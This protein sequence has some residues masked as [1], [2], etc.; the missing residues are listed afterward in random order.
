MSPTLRM[1]FLVDCGEVCERYP[2]CVECWKERL[3]KANIPFR[4]FEGIMEED[5]ENELEGSRDLVYR[6][7]QDVLNIKTLLVLAKSG[8]CLYRQPVTGSGSMDIDLLAG[9]IQ[10]NISF[11][12]EGMNGQPGENDGV[13][14]QQKGLNFMTL[15]KVGSLV[16]KEPGAENKVAEHGQRIF[17]LNYEKFVLLVHDAV[18]I[19]SVLV[20]DHP[21]SFQLRSLLVNFSQ[22]FEKIYAKDL[23]EFVGEV[24]KFDDAHSAVE[25]IF[26]T[27]LLF[28]YA[29]KLISP[30]EEESLDGLEKIVYRTGFDKSQQSGF[31]FIATMCDELKSMLQK[32]TRDIL[33]AIYE[34]LKL[35]YFIPQQIETAAKYMDEVKVSRD[36]MQ[37][38]GSSVSAIYGKPH[39]EEIKQLAN[40]LKNASEKEA[41][42][43]FKQYFNNANSRLEL[44]I[45]EDAIK[46]FDLAK[47]VAVQVGLTKELEIVNTKMEELKDTIQTLEYTNAMKIAVNAEKN[48]DFLKAIQFYTSSKKILEKFKDERNDKRI[49]EIDRR[50]ANLQPKIR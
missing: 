37:Q 13:V 34:L 3:I 47:M 48:K 17:E 24:S 9:F 25:Q 21:P 1:N 29:A 26:E 45:Y 15:E 40:T 36:H 31:F 23:D 41:K 28:P 50:I 30:S 39:D 33:H 35:E 44:G 14:E 2:N 5:Q 42:M 4:D 8:V 22:L 27:D 19:R 46:N 38:A 6:K 18:K 49:K 43:L 32:P 16:F 10:A 11:S 7:Y 12:Q 20:C